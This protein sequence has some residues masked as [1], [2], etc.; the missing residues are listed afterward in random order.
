[1][2]TMHFLPTKCSVT[3][4]QH[5]KQELCT[6]RSRFIQNLLVC[7]LQAWFTKERMWSEYKCQ[8]VSPIV[9][10]H[11]KQIS[12]LTFWYLRMSWFH[13]THL[14]LQVTNQMITACKAH[15]TNTGLNSIW[16][17]PQQVVVDKI[18][19]AIHLNQVLDN[20]YFYISI[21]CILFEFLFKII[22]LLL[23]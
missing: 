1:M 16:D 23:R 5:E 17:Q 11:Q 8:N 14:N 22:S 13:R 10:R 3:L 19:A 9:L 4:S 2:K 20:A 21:T 6:K 12:S 7:K 18:K 15:I